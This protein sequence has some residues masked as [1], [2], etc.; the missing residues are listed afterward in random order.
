MK[1]FAGPSVVQACSRKSDEI[2]RSIPV[3]NMIDFF[4]YR[5]YTVS[6]T[7]PNLY[8]LY[9]NKTPVNKINYSVKELNFKRKSNVLSVFCCEPN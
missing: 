6:L 5:H 9:N 7:A 3:I 1:G 4:F 2:F 8:L